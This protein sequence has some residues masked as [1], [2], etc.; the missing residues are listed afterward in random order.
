MSI[1]HV[2]A[3]ELSEGRF[4]KAL[5]SIHP[6]SSSPTP[7]C[8]FPTWSTLPNSD[9]AANKTAVVGSSNLHKNIKF[10]VS[11]IEM[12]RFQYV[13]RMSTVM[14]KRAKRS[15]IIVVITLRLSACLRKSDALNKGYKI[16]SPISAGFL[17]T[18]EEEMGAYKEVYRQG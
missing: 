5:I 16:T 6:R 12:V 3:C 2:R 13:R 4:L 11:L 8:A 10:V 17:T 1:Y 18:F 15:M 14:K 9:T 7:E